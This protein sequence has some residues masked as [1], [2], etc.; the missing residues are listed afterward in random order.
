MKLKTFSAMSKK[1]QIKT[2]GTDVVLHAD[3]NLFGHMILAAQSRTLDLR[4]VLFHPLGPVPWSLAAT[5]GSPRKTNKSALAKY[6]VQN[7]PVADDIPSPSACIVDG[8][9][10]LQKVKAERK[11]FAEL[12]ELVRITALREGSQSQRLDI[13]FD[14]YKSLSIKNAERQ[15][16]G[17]DEGI[18][19]RN[20]HRGQTIHQW[21]KFLS[22]SEN[23]TSVIKF[24]VDEWRSPAFQQEY[25]DK[26]IYVTSGS[27]CFRVTRDI[28]EVVPELA[29]DHEE[30]DTR[31]LLHSKHAADQGY[32]AVIIAA[33]DTDILIMA[34]SLGH[35]LQCPIYQRRGTS[36]HCQYIDIRGVASQHGID[37]CTSLIGIH[38]FTGCDSVSAF[39]GKGKVKPIKKMSNFRQCFGELGQTFDVTEQQFKEM[40]AF[41][42]RLYLSEKTDCTDINECRYL[43][44]CG[45]KRRSRFLTAST[46]P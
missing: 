46:V 39:A 11:T 38:A 44:F 40:E 12:S 23:K 1:V 31:V 27:E 35:N 34:L 28:A 25:G 37:V 2:K 41:T 22:S 43:M 13:V 26:D 19:Y 5:D 16:R 32:K 17:T 18:I 42:C 3:R 7:V 6:L 15:R 45:E 9:S 24:L 21:R 20:I 29:S 4:D 30:A 36:A 14:V 33:D 10:L 8:M